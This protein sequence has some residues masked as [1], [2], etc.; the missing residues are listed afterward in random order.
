MI[1]DRR[2][3]TA[4]MAQALHLAPVKPVPLHPVHI[5]LLG[6]L[7]LLV[8]CAGMYSVVMYSAAMYSALEKGERGRVGE[9]VG[10]RR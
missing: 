10:R 8:F 1:R 9:G 3:S 2:A 4:L 6:F 7:I 5:D